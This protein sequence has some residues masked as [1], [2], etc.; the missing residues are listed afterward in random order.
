[1]AS[2]LVLGPGG[3]S[4]PRYGS[5]DRSGIVTIFDPADDERTATVDVFSRLAM[6]DVSSRLATVDVSSR[7]AAVDL[8]TRSQSV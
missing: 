5:F 7:L 2:V 8:I 3:Y 6:A 1:M 4:K